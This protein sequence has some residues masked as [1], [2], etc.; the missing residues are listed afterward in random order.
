MSI[1]IYEAWK[2][3]VH[4]LEQ[5]QNFGGRVQA[6][7]YQRLHSKLR[8]QFPT[9]EEYFAFWLSRDNEFAVEVMGPKLELIFFPC[10]RSSLIL[11]YGSRFYR[12]DE[13]LDLLAKPW[14]YW[15]NVDPDENCSA[16]EWGQRKRDWERA[17]P[18][19][20]APYE[21]GLALTVVG[22]SLPLPCDVFP[23]DQGCQTSM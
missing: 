21:I 15:N 19:Y 9:K 23:E 17:Y 6:L 7:A 18:G 12:Y 16:R 1:K 3:P 2:A 14:G 5:A 13:C 11:A 22:E 10:G 8:E 20:Q 4:T